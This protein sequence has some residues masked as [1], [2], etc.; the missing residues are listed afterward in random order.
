M[1]LAAAA[2]QRG[3]KLL[4][5]PVSGGVAGAAAKTLTFMVGGPEND[6]A[7]AQGHLMQMG[8]AVFHCGTRVGDGQRVKICNNAVL[9]SHMIAMAEAFLLG[10]KMGLEPKIMTEIFKTT[11][12]KCWSNEV[13]NPYPDAVPTAPSSRQYQGGFASA[14]MLKDLKLALQAAEGAQQDAGCIQ[15]AVDLYSEHI[16]TGDFAAR[17]FGSIAVLLDRKSP[18]AG[19]V[20]APAMDAVAV[21]PKQI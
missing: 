10:K 11:T 1:E 7:V 13:G 16:L 19:R 4:D 6:F 17:D 20:L 3:C 5:A 2:M 18:A 15:R 21:K 14:L 9:A 8:R 12:A